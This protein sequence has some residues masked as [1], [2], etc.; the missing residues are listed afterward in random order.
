MVLVV[1]VTI[2]FPLIPVPGLR[3]FYY[4]AA[5]LSL[6]IIFAQS[7]KRDWDRWVGNLS[8]PVYMVHM[9]ALSIT[10]AVC[11][12]EHNVYFVLGLTIIVSVALLHFVEAPLDKWRQSRVP[13]TNAS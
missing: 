2:L 8:Y 6:P 12:G 1:G 11:K 3:W 13:S 5:A 7:Q 9:L 10:S 4:T